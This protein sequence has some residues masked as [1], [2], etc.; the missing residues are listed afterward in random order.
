MTGIGV[1]GGG[2]TVMEGGTA[3]STA[4]AATIWSTGAIGATPAFH[5]YEITVLNTFLTLLVFEPIKGL[6]DN[7]H[8]GGSTR[9]GP[10]EDGR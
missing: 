9:N 4:T 1:I 7:R 10:D 8:S 5:R 3:H 6:I 2:A